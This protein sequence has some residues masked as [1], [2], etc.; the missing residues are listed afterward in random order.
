MI[1]FTAVWGDEYL[2]YLERGLIASFKWPRNRA[3]IANA[4]WI[5]LCRDHEQGRVAR[6]ISGLTASSE[7]INVELYEGVKHAVRASCAA[8]RPFLMAPP[9]NVFSEGSLDNFLKVASQPRTCIASAHVRVL[10]SFLDNGLVA[11]HSPEEMVTHAWRHL[12]GSWTNAGHATG[13]SVAWHGGVYFQKLSDRML[14]VQHRLPT[15][16]LSNITREDVDYFDHQAV[17]LGA[18]DNLWPPICLI[19]QQRYRYLGSSDAG[20]VVEITH[21]SRN[22]P[23][24]H[25]VNPV[26]PDAFYGNSLHNWVNREFVSIFKASEAIV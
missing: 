15:I 19:Q 6:A 26:E 18:W 20:F 3:A 25:P 5:V 24:M 16:F 10:P 22:V 21:P 13:H 8:Q 17:C 2:G 11:P 12:H 1:I 9:D 23:A 7:L 4:H 14:A